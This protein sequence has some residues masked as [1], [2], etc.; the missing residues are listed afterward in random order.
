[1][2]KVGGEVYKKTFCFLSHG[3]KHIIKF[4]WKKNKIFPFTCPYAPALR[5]KLPGITL[6]A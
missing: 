5:D 6:K 1:M 3:R 2:S 4:E